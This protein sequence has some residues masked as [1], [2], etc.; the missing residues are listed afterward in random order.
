M[1]Q[2]GIQYLLDHGVFSELDIHFARLMIRLSGKED[3]EIFLAASLVSRATGEGHVCLDLSTV[4]GEPLI[5]G[6]PGTDG[7]VCPGLEEWRKKLDA[8]VKSQNF[9]NPGS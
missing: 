7:F 6:E 2:K 9:K 4:D 8:F 5:T 3:E 1:N